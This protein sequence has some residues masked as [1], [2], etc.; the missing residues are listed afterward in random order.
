MSQINQIERAR[1][2]W[3]VLVD[4]SMHR[5]TTTYGDLGK[6]I[7]VHHRAIR[8]V[9][10]PIQDYCSECKHPPL[11]IL[12]V[13]GSGRPGTG[14]IA[15]AP[16]DFEG[17]LEEV[18]SHN[19]LSE[20]NPFDFA[21]QG[22]SYDSLLATLANEPDAAGQLYTQ[23]KSRGVRQIVFRNAVR[24]AYSMRCAFMGIH[25]PEA[26]EACHIVP[27]ERATPQQRMD[28]RNG[29][30]LN[31]L[32]HRLFDK[33]YVTVTTGG[34]IVCRNFEVKYRECSDIEVALTTGLHDKK[35]EVP[36]LI[37]QR[38][39]AVNIRQHNELGDWEVD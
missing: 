11:T 33:G 15:H 5:R 32:H 7:G 4:A 8:Y 31:S 24:K 12:V 14:F 37:L 34:Q 18:W 39:L 27:W 16:D 35:M 6:A 2:A 26:L 38:P 28:V 20:A 21:A 10:S 19:W 25:I 22:L 9:L 30:L 3:D 36:R 23:I 29:I 1:L 17:G 13:N